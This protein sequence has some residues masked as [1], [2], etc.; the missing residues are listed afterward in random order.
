M[1]S[2]KYNKQ[3]TETDPHT[4]AVLFIGQLKHL[5]ETAFEKLSKKLGKR[6]SEADFQNVLGNLRNVS[7]YNPGN[8]DSCSLYMNH[9][10]IAVLPMRCSRHNS[11]SRAHYISSL[12]KAKHSES[13]QSVVIVC[14]YEAAYASGL[15][16]ARAFPTYSRKSTKPDHKF[17]VNV[18]FLIVDKE[19]GLSQKDIECLENSAHGVRLTAEIV[20]KPCN[21]MNVSKFL[22]EVYGVGKELGIQPVVIR[23]EELK[24]KGLNGIYSVGEYNKKK[25]AVLLQN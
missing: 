8:S 25:L 7:N 18:E 5:N 12:V 2:I 14:E 20:D 19:A 22:A 17:T 13:D 9:A 16:V 21:E 24:E 11:S 23:G 15:A 6:V 4:H 3:L 1:A 10:T